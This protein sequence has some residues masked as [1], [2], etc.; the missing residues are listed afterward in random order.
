MTIKFNNVYIDKTFNVAGPHE[1]RGPLGNK[2]DHTIN[3]FYAGEK[4]IELAEAKMQKIVWE[5]LKT[6]QTDLLIS[7]DLL[8]QL[9][10]SHYGLKNTNVSFQ[11][12]FAAC[13]NSTLGL[14]NGA[15]MIDNNYA[16][17]VVAITSSHNL[18]AEKQFRFPNEY[19]GPKPKTATFTATGAVGFRMSKKPAKYK[20]KTA[21]IGKIIDLNIDNPYHL[22][23]AMT[24]AAADTIYQHLQNTNT[25][26]SDYD[27]ILTG[28]LGRVGKSIF[29]KYIKQV[30]QIDLPNHQ[31]SGMM[32]YDYQTQTVFAGASGCACIPLVL[33]SKILKKDYRRIL[34]VATGALHS[35]TMINQKLSVP[36]IAHAVE[37]EVL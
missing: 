29:K 34:V 33:T 7:G 32:L 1:Q 23:A 9:G 27:L 31:D 4:T 28:D 25:K 12:I 18:A 19:G 20:I 21:T 17:E 35:P 14:I 5:N 3:D 6:A 10:A 2:F 26:P 36:G 13:A 15:V 11:G 8:N 16:K 24:P 30:Y 22:G 37:L